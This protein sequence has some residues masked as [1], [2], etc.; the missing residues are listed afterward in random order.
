[1]KRLGGHRGFLAAALAVAIAAPSLDTAWTSR[2]SSHVSLVDP[3]LR[4]GEVALVHTTAGHAGALSISLAQLG[5]ADIDADVAAD[6]VVARL[7]TEAL[8]ALRSDARVLL[9]TT[10][11]DVMAAGGK[12][13]KRT[14]GFESRRDGDLV[15]GSVSVPFGWTDTR[16]D[17]RG[18]TVAVMDTGI[19]D[20]PDLKGKVVGRVNFV[21]EG[22][23]HRH[24]PGG[25]GTFI[26]G[27][28]AAN[29]GMRGVA[30]EATLVSLRVLNDQGV[31]KLSYVV[32]A[33]DWLL[34]NARR[35]R[36]TVL[37]ISWGAPHAT[38][39]HKSLLSALVEAAW[40][41]GVTVVVASGNDGPATGSVTAPASDP[42]V[43][44]VGSF[45]GDGVLHESSF[46]GR[47]PTLDG[48]AKPDTLAPG[49]HV[50]SLRVRDVEYLDANGQ[51]VGSKND[52]YVHMSGTSAASAY[53]SGFAALMKSARPTAT[54]N[55]IKGAIVTS[56]TVVAGSATTAL[57]ATAA[58]S[59]KAKANAGLAP[60]RLLLA[61]L[62]Q[63]HQLRL[64]R[65][66][67]D[68]V[69]WEGVSWDGV[70]WEAV[71]WETVA[72]EAVTWESV[73]WEGVSWSTLVVTE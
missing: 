21:K 73:T 68:G 13:H 43:I 67:R 24:D 20:H 53:V 34:T 70:S 2:T 65:V 55:D 50:R 40:F 66:V 32:N 36:I 26:A 64:N 47:G 60:S 27:L 22:N 23:S 31:G 52:A 39:Y 29:G 11:T 6:V 49:E 9:A 62:A 35:E 42:F 72:W 54:P 12:D 63:A 61:L 37:N 14:T 58:L 28:I 10:D 56:G 33:F 51:P 69:S 3:S 16:S 59:T 7:T 57:N 30:P 17:G 15:D 71:S 44:A 25:H 4:A 18:V 41:S 19:A 38:T 45:G 48:F 8:D 46:S 5:A 1:M